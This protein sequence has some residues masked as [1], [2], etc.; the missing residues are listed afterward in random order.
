EMASFWGFLITMGIMALLSL[1]TF[2]FPARKKTFYAREAFVLASLT[3]LMVSALG[4]LP[5]VLDRSIP[6]FIDA[7]FETASGFTTTGASIVTDFSRLSMGAKYWRSFTHWLGGM[8]VLVFLLSLEPITSGSG[9]GD[10]IHIMRAE[11][12]GPQ[13]SK[14]V[15]HTLSSARIL[16]LIYMF[17]TVMLIV[18]LVLGGMSVFEAVTIAFGTAG[19]GGFALTAESIGLYSPYIQ[20]VVGV[21][22]MLF[23][24]NFGVYYLILQRQFKKAVRNSEVWMY[25]IVMFT[26]T[27]AIF[28]YIRPLYG[29]ADGLR[30]S[31]FQVSSI[32]TTT[33]FATA[34]FNAWPQFAR[35]LL[36]GL[37]LMGACAGSTGGGFK[38][39]RVLML[40]KSL[41]R[42]LKRALHP[43]AVGRV[44]IDGE[45]VSNETIAN[46]YAFLVAYCLIIIFSTMLLGFEKTS[47]ETNLT[48]VIACLNNIGP[49]LD[50]VGPMGGYAHFSVL[51]KIVLILNMILGRLEIFP[52]LILFVPGVWKKA[53][54]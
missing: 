3:W 45:T 25:L 49:G 21:F 16:Y 23:G 5:F 4:S 31:F 39:S 18:L 24:V 43:N 11:S 41:Q 30:Q 19:T 22:M 6:H 37:M 46:T 17:L 13:V 9:G 42:E 1:V 53:R 50:M 10:S 14:L 7:M 29:T 54:N 52:L 48:A 47:F 38:V 26:A 2:A 34:D 36:V 35:T 33:G 40:F 12:P 15:P 27:I 28:L 32:M 8:G 20:W 51:S 44:H